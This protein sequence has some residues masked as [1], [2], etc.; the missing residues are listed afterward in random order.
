[1][2]ASVAADPPAPSGSRGPREAGRNGPLEGRAQAL[3][4]DLR[5]R[6]PDRLRP[7]LAAVAALVG[8]PLDLPRELLLAEVHGMA[9]VARAIARAKGRALEVEGRLRDL[10]LA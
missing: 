8:V 7:H 5:R 3:A 10:V 4:A 1:M 6:G 9:D 2:G